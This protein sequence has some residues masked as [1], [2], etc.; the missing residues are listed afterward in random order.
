[1]TKMA[2]KKVVCQKF[3]KKRVL[4]KTFSKTPISVVRLAGIAAFDTPVKC[5]SPKCS[6]RN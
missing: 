5:I 1:M 4:S 2:Q 3:Y 6:G